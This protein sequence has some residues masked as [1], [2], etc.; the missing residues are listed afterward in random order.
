MM[1]PSLL[2]RVSRRVLL[3]KAGFNKVGLCVCVEFV[4]AYF[5]SF[6]VLEEKNVGR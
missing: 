5:H 6:V 4:Q 1:M 3:K 2:E